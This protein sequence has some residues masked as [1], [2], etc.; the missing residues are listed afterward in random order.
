MQFLKNNV[1][2]IKGRDNEGIYYL[3]EYFM[4]NHRNNITISKNRRT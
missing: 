4:F 3:D 1:L 2:F